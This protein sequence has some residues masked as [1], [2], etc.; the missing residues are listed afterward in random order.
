VE[1][2]VIFSPFSF[3]SVGTNSVRR[4]E[5]V[6]DDHPKPGVVVRGGRRDRFRLDNFSANVSAWQSGALLRLADGGDDLFGGIDVVPL[7]VLLQWH[8]LGRKW[9]DPYVGVG[10]A[11]LFPSTS[12]FL[13]GGHEIQNIVVDTGAT[14]AVQAGFR[15]RVVP[16]GLLVDAKYLP[17]SLD[18]KLLVAEPPGTVPIEIDADLVT[19]AA[20]LSLRF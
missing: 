12:F 6:E 10:G 3:S 4:G 19:V 14:F 16:I 5:K 13:A 9:F 17:G 20:G 2:R 11:V 18:A 1:T 15:I 7:A 8:P